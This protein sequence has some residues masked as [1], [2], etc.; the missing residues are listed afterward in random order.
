MRTRKKP[1]PGEERVGELVRESW[2]RV[3]V[4]RATAEGEKSGVEESWESGESG[5]SWESWRSELDRDGGGRAYLLRLSLAWRDQRAD[6]KS[7][8][9]Q[10]AEGHRQPAEDA[11]LLFCRLGGLQV[12]SG[13]PL[14]SFEVQ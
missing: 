1:V 10:E 2:E 14:W 9:Q 8:S 4:R 12:H 5:E 7:S 13:G 6:E 3:A 11:C